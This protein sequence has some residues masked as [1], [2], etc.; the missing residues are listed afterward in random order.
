MCWHF[1]QRNYVGQLQKRILAPFC[2]R[3]LPS[4]QN[5][6][7]GITTSFSKFHVP[8]NEGQ[9]ALMRRTDSQRSP[10]HFDP[11]HPTSCYH[12]YGCTCTTETGISECYCANTAQ[13]GRRCVPR[14]VEIIRIGENA[15]CLR[16][17]RSGPPDVDFGIYLPDV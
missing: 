5:V 12:L 7:P 3:W 6:L 17:I 11:P 14:S 4:E 10:R 16:G 9:N 8:I 1:K 15:R 13:S 2:G